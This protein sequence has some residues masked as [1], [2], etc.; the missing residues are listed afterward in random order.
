MGQW[1]PD[2][3]FRGVGTVVLIVFIFAALLI[4]SVRILVT[5]FPFPV[6]ENLVPGSTHETVYQVYLLLHLFGLH[7]I[8][9]NNAVPLPL[10]NTIYKVLGTKIGTNSGTAGIIWD[11]QFVTIG[12]DCIL[13]EKTLL[14]PHAIEGTSI[15]YMPITIGNTVTIGAHSVVLQDVE[16]GDHAIVAAGSIVSKGTR[17]GEGEI[18]GGVPA[19][20]IK[21]RPL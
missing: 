13:G 3:S 12:T 1:L 9:R 21:R 18:W 17:I 14:T 11:G 20:L 5:L 2:N 4:F 15:S 10:M 8:L 19:K 6:G 7:M 16:I